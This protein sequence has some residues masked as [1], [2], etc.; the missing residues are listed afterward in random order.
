[1]SG[2]GCADSLKPAVLGDPDLPPETL[3]L[4]VTSSDIFAWHFMM[5]REGGLS[6]TAFGSRTWKATMT[7]STGIQ[8]SVLR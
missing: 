8:I 6:V 5:S 7:Q 2:K 4:Y 3:P 1:M